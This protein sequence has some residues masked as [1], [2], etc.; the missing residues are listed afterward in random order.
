[1]HMFCV[2]GLYSAFS[3][4]LRLTKW[5]LHHKF[6]TRVDARLERYKTVEISSATAI[7]ERNAFS[8]RVVE[9]PSLVVP[10]RTGSLFDRKF[11]NC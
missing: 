4:K 8:A 1:M 10:I 5:R 6:F 11:T 3:S 9:V 7:N 2:W